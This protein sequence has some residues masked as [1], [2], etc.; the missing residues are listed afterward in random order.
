MTQN[1]MWEDEKY[2][3]FNGLDTTTEEPPPP[4]EPEDE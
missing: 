2:E 4:P 1:E 3:A